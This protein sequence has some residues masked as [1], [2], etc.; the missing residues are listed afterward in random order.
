[1]DRFPSVKKKRTKAH[2]VDAAREQLCP[3]ELGAIAQK[4]VN[5]PNQAEADR[6]KDEIVRGFYGKS[7]PGESHGDGVEFPRS[8]DLPRKVEL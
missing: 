5:A 6:L 4:M 2:P 3:A 7:A 1:M 8:K